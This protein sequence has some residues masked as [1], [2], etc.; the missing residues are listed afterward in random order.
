M[1]KHNALG[2]LIGLGLVVSTGVAFAQPKGPTVTV[3]GEAVDL[4]CYMEGGDRGPAKKDCATACAKAGNPIGV[5]DAKGNLYV[6]AG[7]K[8]HQ[9]AQ[10]MLLSRMSDQVTVTG[11]LVKKG[12]VQMIYIESV[13]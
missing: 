3:K 4:W 9:P 8:D 12:G 2:L 7:L 1:K 10:S 6:A 5:L 11:T 13:K